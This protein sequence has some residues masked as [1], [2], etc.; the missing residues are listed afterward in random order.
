M[1]TPLSKLPLMLALLI[2]CVLS[3]KA[4]AAE[5]G[6]GAAEQGGAATYYAPDPVLQQFIE[7]AL[8]ANPAIQEML[9]RSRAAELRVPQVTSLP[10]PMLNVG[11]AIQRPE[12]RVGSQLNTLSI[13]QVFPWFGKLDLRGQMATQEA[14]ASSQLYVGRQ[15]DVIVAVKRA[16]YDLAYVHTAMAISQEERALLDHYEQLSQSRYSTGQGLQQAVIK[17]QAEITKVVSRLDTLNQ[18]RVTLATRL[19]T[20]MNRPPDTP[21]PPVVRPTLPDV[22]LDLDGLYRLGDEHRQELLAS[23]ALTERSERGIDLAKK[24]YWPDVAIGASYTN[25][26]GRDVLPPPPDNGKN[27]LTVSVG[28]SIP[29]W[30]EKYRAGVQRATEETLAQRRNYEAVQNEVEF[31]VRDQV[32]RL[33]TLRGQVRLFNDVLIPQAEEALRST[34]SAYQTGQVGVLD[35]LDGERVLLQV[36]LGNARQEADFLVALAELERAVGT[37]FPG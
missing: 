6:G 20:F 30:R 21:L 12:T 27:A 19:N 29:L 22:D 1:T 18:Q 14:I 2:A 35:L 31:A 23:R 7:S 4:A 10:D 11:Q 5:Q 28:V 32:A 13:S 17:I 3:A 33:E 36:R 25:I 24:D 15:R 9:A 37:K 34:E 16:F 26:L 8:E